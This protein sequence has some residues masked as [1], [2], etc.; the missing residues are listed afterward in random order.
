[1]KK[2]ILIVGARPNFMKAYP[3]YEALK[4]DFELTLIHTGQHFDAKMSDVF[5]NQ[6][7]FPKPDIHLSLE[8]KTRA[9]DYDNRL[10]VENKEYLKNKDKVINDLISY[11]RELG[12][13]GEIRDKLKIEFGKINPNLVIVFGDVTSTLAA[14]LVAK[15]L[16]IDL[17][18]VESGLRS[19]DMLMPEEV[20]RVLTDHITKYYFITEQSGVDNL[21]KIGITENV[22]I[23]NYNMKNILNSTHSNVLEKNE[24][25]NI[26]T[27][28]FNNLLDRDPIIVNNEESIKFLSNK[29]IIITG[30]TGSIGSEIIIQLLTLGINNLF[31][32]LF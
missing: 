23:L 17:A 14:G 28:N 4:D 15:E 31:L 24:Y 19:G 26:D 16:N 12:Q 20:N 1:M 32:I 2:I 10:Y 18:H 30:G 7:K 21:K 8:K 13:L 22:H 27:I 11:D 5:F 29:N 9:G 25:I 3:V 6:L